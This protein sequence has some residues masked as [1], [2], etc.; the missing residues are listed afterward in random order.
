MSGSC[1]LD[2]MDIIESLT[3]VSVGV[4]V[5]SLMTC[6]NIKYN[7]S[8]YDKKLDFLPSIVEIL[9]IRVLFY[10]YV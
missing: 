10:Q 6:D 1:A 3:W 5:V 4:S 7:M 9:D 8:P 2:M